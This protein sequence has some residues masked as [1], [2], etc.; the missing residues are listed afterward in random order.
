M[1]RGQGGQN[2]ADFPAE[3]GTLFPVYGVFAAVRGYEEWQA[4]SSS[5]PGRVIGWGLRGVGGHRRLLLANLTAHPVE[6]WVQG[7]AGAWRARQLE[8]GNAR[9]LFTIR[10]CFGPAG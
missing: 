5:D 7:L 1:A 3:P 9:R 10:D 4:I 6:T 8:V 2:R